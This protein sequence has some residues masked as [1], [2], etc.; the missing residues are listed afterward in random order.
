MDTS[1]SFTNTLFPEHPVIPA[2]IVIF[3]FRVTVFSGESFAKYGHQL[4][5]NKVCI[6]EGGA[7]EEIVKHRYIIKANMQ[8]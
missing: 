8:L 6:D 2:I 7:T 1:A 3:H 4:P 5:F